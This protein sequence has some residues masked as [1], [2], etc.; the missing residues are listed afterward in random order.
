MNGNERE[1]PEETTGENTEK[2]DIGRE[3]LD[4]AQALV[5]SLILVIMLFTFLARIITVDGTSMVPTLEN[6]DRVLITNLGY[7][8]KQGDIIVFTKKGLRLPGYEDKDQPLVKRVIATA[9]QEVDINFN[10]AQVFVDGVLQDEPYISEP[11]R[12]QLDIQFPVTVPKGC[13]F[14]MG[15]NRN[16]SIDSRDSRIGMIDTR[17]ILGRVLLR[18]MPFGSFGKVS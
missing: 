18:V 10:T 8:P 4:W 17:Y 11:T 5:T 14:V 13:I 12:R 2:L 15:D 16:E 1:K 6:L 7:T 3:L 9:G